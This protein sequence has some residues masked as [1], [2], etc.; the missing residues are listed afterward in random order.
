MAL[1]DIIRPDAIVPSLRAA[2]KK[3]ALLDLSEKA[4]TLTGLP[5]RAIFDTLIQRERLGST[6]I[7]EGIAI[8]HGKLARCEAIFGLFARMERPIPFESL[9]DTPVD[10]IF[11]LLAPETAGA[12]HLNALS[13]VARALRDPAIVTALRSAR[14][15]SAI[16]SVLVNLPTPHAA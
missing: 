2:T 1:D 9:D 15:A 4:A 16:Y 8:P 5:A 6:G 13:R 12:D 7:G 3:Q 10:L 11:L 14:D